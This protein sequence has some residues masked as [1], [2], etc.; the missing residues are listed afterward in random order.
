VP[1]MR[2]GRRPAALVAGFAVA[3]LGVLALASCGSRDQVPSDAAT[4]LLPSVPLTTVPPAQRVQFRPV[5]EFADARGPCQP[6]PAPALDVQ[7]AVPRCRGDDIVEQ[8]V[9]GPAFLLGDAVVA[10]EPSILPG[11]WSVKLTLAEGPAGID[12]FN[13]WATRCFEKRP[14]CPDTGVGS[15]SIAIVFD[16]EV[17][18]APA[19]QA[20]VFSRDLISV[21]VDDQA[22]AE[23]LSL[24]LRPAGT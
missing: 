17:L 20:P 22:T 19:V 15:G 6:V 3:L 12:T 8:V 7:L 21:T 16:G 1:V 14:E 23:A 18:S 5:L 2:A 9:V 10:A 4:T 24:A 13:D 11:A